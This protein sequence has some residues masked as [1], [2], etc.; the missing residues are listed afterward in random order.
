MATEADFRTSVLPFTL[1]QEGGLSTDRKDPGNWTGGKVGNGKLLGTKYG[2]AAASHPGLEIRHLTLAQA[3]DIYW[4]EYVI[5]PRFDRLDLALLLVAFDAGVNC[6]PGR[7]AS[8]L[9]EAEA[10]RGAAAQIERLTALNLAYH[11]KLKTWSRYGTVWGP[12]IEACRKQAHLLAAAAPVAVTAHQPTPAPGSLRAA[13]KAAT[14]PPAGFATQL[15]RVLADALFSTKLK[16][17][18]A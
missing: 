1:H 2:I 7:A 17:A 8:W 12:R 5:A 18:T 6:G 11:K 4:R 3:C 13:P 16:G 10:E 9:K 15:I 14:Q